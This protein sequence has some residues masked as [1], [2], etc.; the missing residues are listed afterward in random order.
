M[1]KDPALD[2]VEIHKLLPAFRQKFFGQPPKRKWWGRQAKSLHPEHDDVEFVTMDANIQLTDQV[3]LDHFSGEIFKGGEHYCK[4]HKAWHEDVRTCLGTIGQFEHNR[5]KWYCADLDTN[6]AVSVGLDKFV[7]VL[8]KHNIE[9]IWEYG[10]PSFNKAH[11]WFFCN[12]NN[13]LLRKFVEVLWSEAEA[14]PWLLKIEEF[15]TRKPNNLLRT[16]GGRH[17]RSGQIM[18]VEFRGKIYKG[19]LNIVKC[20]VACK[21]VEEAYMAKV[22]GDAF[23][24][25]DTAA[26][27]KNILSRLDRSNIKRGFDGARSKKK[28]KIS[29]TCRLTCRIAAKTVR[30]YLPNSPVSARRSINS[31][32]IRK[33]KSMEESS[34]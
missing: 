23:Q 31:S 29:S 18:P 14:D 24:L 19:A 16:P 27:P 30:Q 10:G 3:L 13:V 8:K 20:I 32:M 2:L 17:Q 1:K 7:P 15:P 28:L 21:L 34:S 9:F 6:E 4:A 12:T 26:D 5:V 22:I 11:V 25:G 33:L